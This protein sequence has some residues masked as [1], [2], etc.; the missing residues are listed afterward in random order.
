MLHCITSASSGRIGS[1]A[2]DLHLRRQRRNGFRPAARRGSRDRL[3]DLLVAQPFLPRRMRPALLPHGAGHVVDLEREL[4]ARMDLRYLFDAALALA[5]EQVQ[6][7]A[8]VGEGIFQ[9]EAATL[10]GKAIR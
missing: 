1:R 2:A 3:H 7:L 5:P 4:V 8:L 10:A 6:A 9:E